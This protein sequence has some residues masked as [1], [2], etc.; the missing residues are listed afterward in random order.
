[1]ER[2]ILKIRQVYLKV[3]F[4]IKQYIYKITSC[5]YKIRLNNAFLKIITRDLIKQCL[6]NGLIVTLI[7]I[8]D[9]KIK[10]PKI[11]HITMNYEL[12][13]D[14]LIAAVGISGVFL[15]LYCSN[16]M[17]IFTSRYMNAPKILT[18]L[19]ERDF[20]VNKCI[21]SI[22]QFLVLSTIVLIL[23]FIGYHPGFLLV[24]YC[25]IRAI[26]IIISYGLSGRRSFQISDVCSITEVLYWNI[27]KNFNDIARKKLFRKD[28]NFQNHYRII[29]QNNLDKIEEIIDYTL[30]SREVK[31][32]AIKNF[33]DQNI[34]LLKDYMNIKNNIRYDSFWYEEKM[35]FTKWHK[36]TDTEINIALTTGTSLQPKKEKNY[37]WIENSIY[38]INEKCLSVV[39]PNI[40]F[41][42]LYHWINK[43]SSLSEYAVFSNDVS[44][45]L[46]YVDSLKRIVLNAVT[47]KTDKYTSLEKESL[48]ENLMLVYIKLILSMRK[49]VVSIDI[50]KILSESLTFTGFIS[51]PRRLYY[52]HRDVRKLYDCIQAELRIEGHRVTPDWYVQQ[53]I[54]KHIYDDMIGLYGV[55]DDILNHE[56]LSLSEEFLDKNYYAETMI[57]YSRMTEMKTKAEDL[58]VFIEKN[59]EQLKK[60]HKEKTIIWNDNPI[61]N[62]KDKQHQIFSDLPKKWVKC[63]SYFTIENYRQIDEFPDFIGECYNQVCEFL[64]ESIQ[65]DDYVSFEKAYKNFVNLA[66]VYSDVIR[67]DLVSVKEPYMQDAVCNVIAGP[68]IE[69]GYISGYAYIWG[70]ISDKECWKNLVTLEFDKMLKQMAK[71]GIEEDAVCKNIFLHLK[72]KK[73]TRPA[74]YNRDVIHS[75]WKSRFIRKIIDSNY[76]V[77]ENK[78]YVKVLKSENPLLKSIIGEP[79]SHF[80][81]HC[82]A[83]E[84]FAVEIMNKYVKV[85]EKYKSSSGWENKYEK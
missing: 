48:V 47:D 3:V 76:L 61:L 80:M 79:E 19:F 38:T 51:T 82:E 33:L 9:S 54:A 35:V 6:I 4:V 13:S 15:G 39:V 34:L 46:R 16:M 66:F 74:I 71:S 7:M 18:D 55:L 58:I 70:E 67:K 37:F 69:L 29:T 81:L 59:I 42:V 10:I 36:A 78:G 31:E 65:D 41:K 44:V 8:L 25:F 32:S 20:L 14:L 22:S 11:D 60:Y 50:S 77:W 84:V 53:I 64:I 23:N 27:R 17:S 68:M 75:N 85:D 56:V 12:F 45:Y 62:F 83:Y 28:V 40:S 57:V 52:N 49:Y 30:E 72:V 21:K 5:E 43:V 24:I 2:I 73:Y 63:S 1:M 26:T